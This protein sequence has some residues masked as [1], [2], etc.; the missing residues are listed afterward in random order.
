MASKMKYHSSFLFLTSFL[1]GA[2]GI[3][4]LKL[5]GLSHL[6]IIL[7]PISIMLLYTINIFIFKGFRLREDIA[8]DNLY[9]L[10]FL[11]TLTSL[12]VALYLFAEK[13]GATEGIISNFGVA[14]GT[15]IFG[16]ALRVL[17]YQMRQDPLEVELEARLELSESAT[18]LK[19]ILDN[20]VL[21][22]NSFRRATQ[23]SIIEGIE[24]I[25]GQ[26]KNNINKINNEITDLFIGLN[27]TI[28]DI[29]VSVQNN[30]GIFKDI[31]KNLVV[32]LEDAIDRV[33]NLEI[34]SDTI[35]KQLGPAFQAINLMINEMQ[36]RG[37]EEEKQVRRLTRVVKRAIDSSELLDNQFETYVNKLEI[38]NE[39]CENIGLVNT[40]FEHL[41]NQ[42]ELSYTGIKKIY[43]HTEYGLSLLRNNSDQNTK[44]S[45]ERLNKFITQQSEMITHFVTEMQNHLETMFKN[46]K[47]KTEQYSQAISSLVSVLEDDV[48]RIRRHNHELEVELENSR[49]TTIKVHN[50]LA[51]MAGLLIE[52]L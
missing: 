49:G 4:G 36:T 35:E 25:S 5:Y 33:N 17:L 48:G 31:S 52:K 32:T 28:N 13:E 50:S 21:D 41:N 24:E 1:L 22:M 11:F 42:V 51:S 45:T 12:S 9:Y 44:I 34:Q 40:N 15:T 16:I 19:S 39:F 38:L 2:A 8:G 27:K 20:V 37:K 3:V 7:W 23:Q 46:S 47:D 10:G 14:L 29:F 43:E 30:A 26:S 6:I 18:R